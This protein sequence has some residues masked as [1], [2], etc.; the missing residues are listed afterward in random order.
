MKRRNFLNAGLLTAGVIAVP[1]FL[2]ASTTKLIPTSNEKA[3]ISN[4]TIF[5]ASESGIFG[6]DDIY[7]LGILYVP[8][9]AKNYEAALLQ[10]R[11]KHNFRSKLSYRSNNKFKIS[12]AKACIDF[13]LENKLR[14]VAKIVTKQEYLETFRGNYSNG[15]KR[16]VK[17]TAYQE[18]LQKL[19][20]SKG[21][22]SLFK[23]DL[24]VKSQSTF[25][26]SRGFESKFNKEVELSYKAVDSNKSNL[27]QLTDLLT[28]CVR[29]DLSSDIQNKGKIEL[30]RYLKENLKT[31]SLSKGVPVGSSFNVV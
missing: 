30:I 24:W 21:K 6:K 17:I 12:Y 1:S 9:G 15:K 7:V 19:D 16:R 10:L 5:F 14:F 23:P 22:L 25:G 29:G 31:S 3:N 8:L 27:L 26:P 4:K 2:T 20:Y 13:F 28:G 11:E 18:L